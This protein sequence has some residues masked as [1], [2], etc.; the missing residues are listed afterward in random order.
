MNID[1]P[2][3]PLTGLMGVTGEPITVVERDAKTL[4]EVS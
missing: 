1:I 3:G 2:S 4:K